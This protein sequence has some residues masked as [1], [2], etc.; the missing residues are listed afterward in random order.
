MTPYQSED[1][2]PI[3]QTYKGKEEK[4]KIVVDRKGESNQAN[5]NALDLLLKPANP[6]PSNTESTRSFREILRG[7]L[8]S[9]GTARFCS[10]EAQKYTDVRSKHRGLP[11][12]AH[13][14]Q[15]ECHKVGASGYT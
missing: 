7:E 13:K 11:G 5:K 2:S 3:L 6:T 1:P 8:K 15:V 9:C 12:L 14:A 10:G 4:V